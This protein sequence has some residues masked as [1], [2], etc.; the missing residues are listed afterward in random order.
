LNRRGF[1][2]RFTAELNAAERSGQP[3]GLLQIDL[4]NFKQ[5]NDTKGHAAGD[6]ILIWVVRSLQTT[7]RPTDWIGRL[8]GDEFAV[9]LPGASRGN[10]N[11]VADRVRYALTERAP[12]SI[13]IAV[14]P[15]DGADPDE[16]HRRADT[17]LYTH[18]DGRAGR[19]LNP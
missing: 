7:L 5:I 13:G 3:L 11:E 1:A 15:I 10:A 2:E 14:Y 16:L 9:L 19:A 17:E 8:G 6:E 18:K 12:A 4:D